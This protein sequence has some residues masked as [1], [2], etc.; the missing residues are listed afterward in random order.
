[1]LDHFATIFA[2]AG[3]VFLLGVRFGVVQPALDSPPPMAAEPRFECGPSVS[4]GHI[5]ICRGLGSCYVLG[6]SGRCDGPLEV[7]SRSGRAYCNAHPPEN[8]AQHMSEL[9]DINA[10]VRIRL[11]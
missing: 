4:G 6:S 1:M 7:T 9:S 10:E 2:I 3:I 11:R 8:T 5:C